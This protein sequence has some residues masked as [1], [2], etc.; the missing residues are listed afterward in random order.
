MSRFDVLVIGEPLIE[1]TCAEPLERGVGFRLSFSGDALNAAAAAAAAGARTA[2]LTR[3][4][5]D[6]LGR[7]LLRRVTE[8]GVEPLARLVDAPTGAYLSGADPDGAAEFVY[9]RRGSA[10]SELSLDDLDLR[11]LAATRG[12]LVSGIT[13]AL[14]ADAAVAVQAAV[15]AVAAAGG[16]VVYDPNYRARLTTPAQAARALAQ[17][18]RRATLVTPSC[19][20]DTEPLLGTTDPVRAAE[21][22]RAAGAGAAAITMGPRGVL[23]LDDGPPQQ[24]PPVPAADVVDQTGA[25]DV[26]AGTAAARLALGDPMSAAVALGMAA[27]ALSLAGTGGTGRVPSLAESRAAL[28]AG[29]A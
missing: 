14:S 8:L 26:L 29:R 1:L 9:L 18:A 5:D 17:I 23:L 19:P 21:L 24:L 20:G 27:A 28:S 16:V 25:G 7:R 4:G 13:V 15:G 10:A 12:L 22:V 6:P 2:L 11:L 3:V